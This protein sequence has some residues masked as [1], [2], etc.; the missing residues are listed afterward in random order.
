VLFVILN[1]KIQCRIRDLRA[2]AAGAPDLPPA[3]DLGK[4]WNAIGFSDTVPESAKITLQSLGD[5]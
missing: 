2:F 5:H 1:P 3:K 4:G